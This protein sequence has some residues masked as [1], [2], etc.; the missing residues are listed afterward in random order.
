MMSS[1][2]NSSFNYT[3]KDPFSKQD[4]IHTF[5]GLGCEH[6]FLEVTIQPTTPSHPWPP[7]PLQKQK[8]PF[9]KKYIAKLILGENEV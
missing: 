9:E 1:S 7:P 3:C 4:S 8:F 6:I 5:Q 2:Q